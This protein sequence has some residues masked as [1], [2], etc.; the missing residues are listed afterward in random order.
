M[1]FFCSF[2]A[3]RKRLIQCG[4][5]GKKSDQSK[6][7]RIRSSVCRMH[8]TEKLKSFRGGEGQTPIFEAKGRNHRGEESKIFFCFVLALIMGEQKN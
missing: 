5:E 3:G 1:Y 6:S 8:S 2:L 7:I 4:M